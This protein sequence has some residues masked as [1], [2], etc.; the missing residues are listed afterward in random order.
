M[1][2]ALSGG[3]TAIGVRGAE[4]AVFITQKKVPDRLIDPTSLT[5]LHAVTEN[6]GCLTIGLNPDIRAQVERIRYEA[7]EFW[8]N[9]GYSMPAHALAKRVAD[10]CQVNTQEASSR[11][12]AVL[13]LFIGYD[14]EKGAQLFKVDLA[15]HYLP[16]KAVAMGKYEQEAMNFLE[17]RV[18]DLSTLDEKETIEMAI[19]AMQHILST[20]FKGTEVEIGVVT[21]GKKYRVLTETEI[22]ERV[23]VIQDKADA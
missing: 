1:K 5:S 18:A 7:N 6:I 17:K 9:N 3:T 16:Y 14:D 23:N 19:M 20:D 2:A 8:F 11:A 4:T 12:L 15:G 10:L 22:E 13:M 21:K